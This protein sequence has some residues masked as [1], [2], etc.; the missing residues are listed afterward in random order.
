MRRRTKNRIL[1]SLV[2]FLLAF[3]LVL[4]T[5]FTIK[6]VKYLNPF[7]FSSSDNSNDPNAIPNETLKKFAKDNDLDLSEW[8]ESLIKTMNRNPETEDFVLNYPYLKDVEVEMDL[9]DIDYEDSIP[10]LMQWDK[11]WGYAP[12]GDDMIAT[13]GCGPT[14]L[15]MV[16]MYLLKDTKYNPKYIS[17]FSIENGYYEPGYGTAWTLMSEGARQ[18]G[19]NS[20]ELPLDEGI[21]KERLDAGQ[22]II[23]IMDKGDFTTEG[24][25]IVLTDYIDGQLKIKDCNSKART[26]KLWEYD[27]IKDQILNLWAY[28]V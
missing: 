15:S 22:P 26:E 21:I 12:Y 3:T 25:F 17:D 19:V 6:A 20:E 9:S 28:S 13:L 2:A 18:L 7:D 4:F 10:H 14:S 24:H 11:R 16:C 8:P 1:I 23:C 27:A 5:G